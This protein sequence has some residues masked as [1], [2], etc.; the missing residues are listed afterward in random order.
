MLAFF[1]QACTPLKAAIFENFHVTLTLSRAHVHLG[2]KKFRL[3]VYLDFLQSGKTTTSFS[4]MASAREAFVRLGVTIYCV[5]F[6]FFI[7]NGALVLGESEV[8]TEDNWDVVLQGHWM[9]KL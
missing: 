8:I 2:N 7:L 6:V 3:E 5:F 4:N 9:I 1:E